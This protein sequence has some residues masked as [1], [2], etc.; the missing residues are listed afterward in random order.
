MASEWSSSR[1]MVAD[2]PTFKSLVATPFAG[3]DEIEVSLGAGRALVVVSSVGREL[4]VGAAWAENSKSTRATVRLSPP[5]L[6]PLVTMRQSQPWS[7][8]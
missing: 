2:D 8:R 4:A 1:L 5:Q 6:K 7:A 3:R